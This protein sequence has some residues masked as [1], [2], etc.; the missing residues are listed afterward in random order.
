M[1]Y[2]GHSST[3]SPVSTF[4]RLYQ[5]LAWFV[6]LMITLTHIFKKDKA[7]FYWFNKICVCGKKLLLYCIANNFHWYFKYRIMAE[8]HDNSW[9]Y[10]QLCSSRKKCYKI[11]DTRTNPSV[12]FEICFS[13]ANTACG[14]NMYLA[15]DVTRQWYIFSLGAHYSWHILMFSVHLLW[16]FPYIDPPP[17]PLNFHCSHLQTVGK[18]R[19]TDTVYRCIYRLFIENLSQLSH[20]MHH[21]KEREKKV[22]LC[23][24]LYRFGKQ[25]D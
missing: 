4:F 19:E 15:P 23:G 3:E 21:E 8:V 25:P 1:S 5:N 13:C 2:T 22:T 16:T 20:K 18:Q 24:I 9:I 17:P 6:L 7:R 12:I 11:V 10:I 14:K